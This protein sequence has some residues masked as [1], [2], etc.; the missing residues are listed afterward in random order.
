MARKNSKNTKG[1]I[2]SAAWHLF[3]EQG[4]DETTVDNIVEASGTSKGSFYHYFSSK[5]A[6]MSSLSYLFDEKYEELRETMNP[7]LNPFEK[8]ILMNKELF[9]MIENTISIDM[10][11]RLFSVQLLTKDKVNLT[12]HNRTYYKLLRE[13][14][15]EGQKD[16]FFREDVTVNDIIKA[17]A[18]FERGIMYDWCLCNGEY[19]ICQYSSTILP[20]FLKTYCRNL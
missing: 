15:L 17:Y 19:S 20:I 13:I 6:L 8:L 7:A 12:D 3:Y 4:F 5:D 9:L 2:V 1:K 18:M 16:G 10:L 14:V 11:A